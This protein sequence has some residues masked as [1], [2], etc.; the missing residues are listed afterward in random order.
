MSSFRFKQFTVEQSRSA[1]KVGTDGVLL[2]AWTPLHPEPKRI[3]DVGC[4]T[5]V[6][7]LM[8]AQRTSQTTITALDI[9][10]DCVAETRENADRSPWGECIETRCVPVQEFEADPFDLV[11]SNPPYFVDSLRSP[12][13]GRTT[14]RHT[15]SLRFEELIEAS[16]RLLKPAGRLAVVLPVEEGE[17]FLRLASEYLWLERRL[18]VQTTPR[19]PVKRLL[20]LFSRRQ[21]ATGPLVERLV[22][23]SGPEEFTPE[24]RTLTGDFYLKF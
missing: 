17:R 19:R 24:Y 8:M 4:G 3:L 6:I 18:E 15:D 9:D 21:P 1:M 20:M 16:L 22:I 14:A 23:Q 7:A 5:G 13:A 12:D 2:G 10:P 11:V